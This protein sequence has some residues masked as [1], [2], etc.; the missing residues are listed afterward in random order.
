MLDY[1]DTHPSAKVRYKKSD[2]VLHVDSDAT[3]LV[4]PGSK[5]RLAGYYY[6][7]SEYTPTNL[8]E[9]P[10]N[11]PVHVEC[12][13]LKHVVSLA[14]EAETGALYDNCQMAIMM[15]TI[16]NALEHRQTPTPIKSDNNTAVAFAKGTLKA[17]KSK[18]WDMQYNWI[19]DQEQ[20]N[21][22]YV[23]RKQGSDNNGDYYTKHFP[24]S[25]HHQIR[26]RY[27]LKGYHIQIPT[28]CARVC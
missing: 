24:C 15:K 6:L 21:Q 14:A 28:L 23:Y 9:I 17:K 20:Q 19:K 2:M 13:L 8:N 26:P 10:L 1:L 4:A 18:T 16:L 25:Y 7:S 12:K 11:A 27:I 3:Y 22:F 5:S